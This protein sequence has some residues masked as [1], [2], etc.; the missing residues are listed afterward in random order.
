MRCKISKLI[1]IFFVLLFHK[2]FRGTL[3]RSR[4]SGRSSRSV[5][6]TSKIGNNETKSIY[7]KAFNGIA[8]MVRCFWPGPFQNIFP[9]ICAFYKSTFIIR[10]PHYFCY[11]PLLKCDNVNCPFREEVSQHSS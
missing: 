7:H 3:E 10:S 5:A 2:F 6:R 4:P 9:G 1:I 11:I 8:L